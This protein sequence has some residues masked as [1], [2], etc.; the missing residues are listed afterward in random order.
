MQAFLLVGAGGALGAMAR[1]G[2]GIVVGRLGFSGFPY[3]T[4]LV[5]ITGSFAMGLLI[6]YL[7]H[8]MPDNQA[9]LRLFIAIG[10]LG[11]FTTLSS[12]S[13]DAVTLIE[14]GQLGSAAFYIVASVLVSIAALFV[15]LLIMRVFA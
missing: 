3:A 6:G 7:A 12:F 8:A 15:G 11:G 10:V 9:G 5:N 1:Y 4:M 13:L 14:R 2:T